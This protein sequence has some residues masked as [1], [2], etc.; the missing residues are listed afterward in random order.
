MVLSLL[1]LD[2]WAGSIKSSAGDE[3]ILERLEDKKETRS[4]VID[5][6]DPDSVAVDAG[7]GLC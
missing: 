4:N 3:G 5:D 7:A 2:F 1:T 6:F